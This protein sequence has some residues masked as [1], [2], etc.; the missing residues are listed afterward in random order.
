M[1]SRWSRRL[2]ARGWGVA[3]TIPAAL[4]AA[5]STTYQELL[6]VACLAFG[7]LAASAVYS[8]FSRPSIEIERGFHP[9]VVAVGEPVTVRLNLRNRGRNRADSRLV[10]LLPGVAGS[11]SL[12]VPAL[13]PGTGVRGEREWVPARRGVLVVPGVRLTHLDPFGLIAISTASGGSDRILVTPRVSAL[14]SP[15]SGAGAGDGLISR[16]RALA[17]SVEDD[18]VTREYRV[19]D[20]I[21]RVHWRASA[22]HGELMVRQDEPRSRPQVRVLLDTRVAAYTD[23]ESAQSA[24]GEAQARSESFEWA[25]RM[26]ASIG[27]HL[28]D[29]GFRVSVA[30]TAGS[31]VVDPASGRGRAEGTAAFLESLATVGLRES[32]IT[33][34]ADRHMQ[35]ECPVFAIVPASDQGLL[36]WVVQSRAMRHP[37]VAF[38]FESAAP[39]A[40]QALA[41]AGWKCVPVNAESDVEAAWARAQRDGVV[42]G[43]R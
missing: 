7:L 4:T 25:V 13:L 34:P 41:D 6:V 10:E 31:Q 27:V 30:E 14:A 32:G 21:Q 1:S 28:S 9:Q 23:I 11:P 38:V 36:E 26:L 8:I 22:R 20:P 37:G 5:Y 2:T 12:R 42:A 33:V 17:L 35:P 43:A 19:G 39:A 29:A 3:L 15:R 18:P 24:G 40:S 16:N